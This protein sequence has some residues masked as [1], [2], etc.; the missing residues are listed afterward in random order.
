MREGERGLQSQEIPWVSYSYLQD[1][2]SSFYPQPSSIFPHLSSISLSPAVI[3]KGRKRIP[4]RSENSSRY[5]QPRIFTRNS[6]RRRYNGQKKRL[7]FFH[8]PAGKPGLASKYFFSVA[9]EREEKLFSY[10]EVNEK[11]HWMNFL[12]RFF[13]VVETVGNIWSKNRLLFMLVHWSRYMIH[14]DGFNVRLFMLIFTMVF[15]KLSCFK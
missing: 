15:S 7:P 8:T 6:T 9:A 1:C 14:K 2:C 3:Q 11:A 4:V 12:I 13:F 5:C 10:L